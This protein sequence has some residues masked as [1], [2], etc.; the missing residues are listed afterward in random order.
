MPRRRLVRRQQTKPQV[1]A[2]ARAVH[3]VST[4]Q[5]EPAP[6][7]PSADG[8]LNVSWQRDNLVIVERLAGQI[9]VRE[10][11]AEYACFIRSDLDPAKKRII[12]DHPAVLGM[13][14]EG[15]WT[16]VLWRSTRERED[17]C[18]ALH[19]D[20]IMTYEGDV[21][22]VRRFMTDTSMVHATPRLAFLDIETDSRVAPRLAAEGNARILC[23]AV[24]GADGRKRVGVLEANTD[25]AER[26]LLQR[27]FSILEDYDQ[28]VAWN[29]DKFDFPA[30][31]AR[32]GRRGVK[33]NFARWL[34]LDHMDLFVRMNT[35]AAESGDEK[36]F[37]ALQAIATA[38]LGEGKD[39]FDA[40]QTWQA[41]AAGGA[42]RQR[43]VRYCVKDTDLLRRLEEKTGYVGLLQTLAETCNVFADSRGINPTI[44]A[45][46]FLLK[47]GAER[48]YRFPSSFQRGGGTKFKGAYVM[49]PQCHGITRNV[50]VG[51]FASLYPSIIVTWNMSPETLVVGQ[52]HDDLTVVHAQGAAP[53]EDCYSYSP[54]TGRFFRTDQEGILPHAV[55]EVLRLRKF[56]NDEKAK[57]PPGSPKWVEANRKST[58]Y[59]IAANSFYGVIG[60]PMSRFFNREV[61]ESVTQCGAW[62][63]QETIR[64]GEQ[65]SMVA[66]YG[67]TDSLFIAGCTRTQFEVFVQWCNE[68]FYPVQLAALG[69]KDNRIKLA[70]E[71]EFERIIFTSAKRYIGRYVHYKGTMA[72]ESSKPEIKGLEFKRGDSIRLARQVQAEV[73]DLLLGG[74]VLRPTLPA[75]ECVE[76]PQ[77][78]I[79]AMQRWQDHIL[80]GELQLEDVVISKRLNKK[81]HEY[82]RKRKKDGAWAKQLPH[83]E[84]ARKLHEAGEDMSEGAKVSYF[85]FDA[86]TKGD[87][88]YRTAADWDGTC[89]RFEV[90]EKLT[91]PP[92]ERLLAAAFP[93]VAWPKLF[94]SVRPKAPR[95]GR[96]APTPPPPPPQAAPV[97][98]RRLKAHGTQAFTT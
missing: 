36:Q 38:L 30:I 83:I 60:S 92:T 61:A 70:Y 10:R 74:G 62:L 68:D 40:S 29:G 8:L 56:W 51:D 64:A 76:D 3:R 13:L 79:D 42:E 15:V 80:A 21:N 65:R 6:G 24:V 41:W 27:L 4:N 45:E 44:Q 43:L 75:S 85:V 39:N 81:L 11:R 55:K 34:W 18:Q 67:D 95:R 28:V 33:V 93:T 22:P 89:D 5:P 53:L 47:L 9:V 2:P 96:V 35:G 82:S 63:I 52:E 71:K 86:G 46:G 73:V 66:I 16:R 20:G 59:K 48:D 26:A 57:H 88:E 12:R 50:H 69:C 25:Q 90:W 31:Q 77:V 87:V 94:G 1:Q 17:L 78:F 23:W 19:R 97:R 32:C 49:E 98:R 91:W 84:L 72:D 58:A 14:E 7:A 54:I 37:L